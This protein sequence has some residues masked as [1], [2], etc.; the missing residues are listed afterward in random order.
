MFNKLTSF[1]EI[2]LNHGRQPE[3]NY[4]SATGRQIKDEHREAWNRH[5]FTY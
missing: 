4:L 5:G 3:R 1:I 2:L